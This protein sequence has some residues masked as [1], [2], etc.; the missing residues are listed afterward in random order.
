[1]RLQET[2]PSDRNSTRGTHTYTQ[3]HGSRRPS[4]QLRYFSC[5]CRCCGCCTIA[6]VVVGIVSDPA[7]FSSMVGVVQ[8]D[9]SRNGLAVA[10]DGECLWQRF[11]RCRIRTTKRSANH[12]RTNSRTTA[13]QNHYRTDNEIETVDENPAWEVIWWRTRTVRSA[14]GKLGGC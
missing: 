1:M 13:G 6:S 10:D 11:R 5:S 7:G 8:S 9:Q 14:G 3:R 4:Y 2:Q 12:H